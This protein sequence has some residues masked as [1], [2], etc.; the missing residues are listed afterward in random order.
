MAGKRLSIVITF[1]VLFALGIPVWWN[2]TTTYRSN[3]DF[4]KIQSF[5]KQ[6]NNTLN[7]NNSGGGGNNID[8]NSQWSLFKDYLYS[9][10]SDNNNRDTVV[11]SATEYC[12]SFTLL[13]ADPSSSPF[14]PR[15]DFPSLFK[16]Q[17]EPFIEQISDIANFTIQSKVAHYATLMKTPLF[18]KDLNQ[19]NI[20]LQSLSEYINPNEWNLDSS[21]STNQPTLNFII[22]IPSQNNQSPLYIRDVKNKSNINS[23]LIPQW[24]GIIIHNVVDTADTQVSDNKYLDISAQLH[25]EMATFRYQLQ[26]LL[27][28]HHLSPSEAVRLR[29]S[30]AHIDQ[31]ID[32]YTKQNVNVSLQTL[33]SLA[34]LI[35]GLPN[36][37]VLDNIQHLV[38]NAT[39]AL[40]RAHHCLEKHDRLCALRA[41]K[42]ALASSETAFFDK[43]MLS[44]LYFP[45]E[46]KYAVYTPLFVPVCFPIV[47]GVFQEYKNSRAKK[48]K[49]YNNSNNNNQ[50]II[51]IIVIITI[52]IKRNQIKII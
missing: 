7:N 8:N 18:D 39:D 30:D 11:K 15:W 29:V 16:S 21:S 26:E 32:R 19:Y 22:F 2:T 51:V 35:D 1:I 46:H 28:L 38:A 31:L 34:A 45:D 4:S 10:T 44:Q 33:T 25:N 41:S 49:N 42:I 5:N 17:L 24:G 14:I 43:N 52:M 12:L 6:I 20:P 37:R 27:G 40:D 23:F 13:N 50:I 9:K 47:A 36:M 3:V 48:A